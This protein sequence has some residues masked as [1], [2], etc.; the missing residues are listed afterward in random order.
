MALPSFEHEDGLLQIG[1]GATRAAAQE[2]SR[3]SWGAL[4]AERVWQ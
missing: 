3:G 2:L 4:S 1:K